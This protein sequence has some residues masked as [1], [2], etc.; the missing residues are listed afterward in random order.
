MALINTSGIIGQTLYYMTINITGSEFMTYLLILVAL[1]VLGSVIFKMP[2]EVTSI[3]LFPVVIVLMASSNSWASIGGIFL[4]Y[5]AFMF[6]FWFPT[7]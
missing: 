1:F 5:R 4:L 6:L 3:L 2:A 7:R